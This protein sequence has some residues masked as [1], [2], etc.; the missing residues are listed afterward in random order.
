M[1]KTSTTKLS[2]R[3]AG[4]RLG[5]DGDAAGLG[6]RSAEAVYT[7]PV[8]GSTAT[9]FRRERLGCK[10]ASRSL[11][12]YDGNGPALAIGTESQAACSVEHHCIGA[13]PNS[14]RCHQ[15]ACLAIENHHPPA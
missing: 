7:A 13:F 11:G 2:G 15:V 4:R 14:R 9:Q 3:T 12:A 8:D 5:F 1:A 10:V 6:P